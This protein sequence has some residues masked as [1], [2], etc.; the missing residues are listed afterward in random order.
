MNAEW[1]LVVVTLIGFAGTVFNVWVMTRIRADVSDL[2]VWALEKFIDKADARSMIQTYLS[3][4][5]T[6]DL[7]HRAT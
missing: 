3:Q 1:A 6:A 2:K 4:E 5:R 7:R